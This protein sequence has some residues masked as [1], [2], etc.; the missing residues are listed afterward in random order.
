[1]WDVCADTRLS[2]SRNEGQTGGRER[3]AEARTAPG[4][5]QRECSHRLGS[6][7]GQEYVEEDK[8]REKPTVREE[9]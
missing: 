6:G 4:S 2:R 8:K 5:G 7:P 3:A 1:M 9:A